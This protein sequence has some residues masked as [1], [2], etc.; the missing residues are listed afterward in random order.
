MV[1]IDSFWLSFNANNTPLWGKVFNQSDMFSKQLSTGFAFMDWDS[2][3]WGCSLSV[4]VGIL[5]LS[6]MWERNDKIKY[7]YEILRENDHFLD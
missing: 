3:T 1:C 4:I 6:N 7:F 2:V 5:Y